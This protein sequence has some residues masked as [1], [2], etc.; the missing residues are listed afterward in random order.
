MARVGTPHRTTVDLDTVARHLDRHHVELARIALTAQAGGQYTFVG[1]L[2]L[3]VIDVAPVSAHQLAAE[4]MATGEAVSDLELNALAHT[5]AHDTATPLDIVTVDE[6][7]GLLLA[8][9]NGRMVATAAGIVVM[10]AST[11]PLRASSRPEKRASDLYDIG[12]LLVDADIDAA[13]LD[14]MPPILLS[15]I[16]DRLDGWFVDDAGRDRT[17]REVRRFDEPS[18]DFDLAADAVDEIRRRGHTAGNHDLTR[19]DS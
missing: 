14:A 8:A 18:L 6:A 9:A 17:Y 7:D 11:V 10:K 5:W 3:D 4:L 13:D 12:R 16:V 19:K 2:D 1:D 15:P